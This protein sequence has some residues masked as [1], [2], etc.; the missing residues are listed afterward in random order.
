MTMS[1]ENI[2]THLREALAPTDN[3][4]PVERAFVYLADIGRQMISAMAAL[5]VNDPDLAVSDAESKL[6]A[7]V[8]PFTEAIAAID[9]DMSRAVMAVLTNPGPVPYDH[10]TPLFPQ[11]VVDKVTREIVQRDAAFDDLDK[12]A[13]ARSKA[14]QTGA[15]F[16]T[17]RDLRRSACLYAIAELAGK[18]WTEAEGHLSDLAHGYDP[19]T[20]RADRTLTGFV[21]ALPDHPARPHIVAGKF[22][23]DK[24][25]TCPPGKCPLNVED[26]TAQDLLWTY[27]QRRRELDAEFADDLEYALRNAGYTPGSPRPATSLAPG[28]VNEFTL[29]A[30]AVIHPNGF[31]MYVDG[32]LMI[33][34]T[35]TL[36][37]AEPRK[38]ACDTMGLEFAR[39]ELDEAADALA[40]AKRI[41][42]ERDD[43]DDDLRIA[44][45]IHEAAALEFARAELEVEYQFP[46]RG[47][48]QG[49]MIEHLRAKADPTTGIVKS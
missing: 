15:K 20:D 36:A 26:P 32:S 17:A 5:R 23:S 19:N 16:Y 12:T 3:R 7:A 24:Y 9:A 13:L 6:E 40:T 30:D 46:D 34:S 49:D 45:E 44:H 21:F 14:V 48:P 4:D 1:P 31:R 27:A 47:T 8:A 11:T 35:V 41:D 25:P 43:G 42:A 10:T 39:Q 2:A 38:R 37:S 28:G 18:G 33:T 29:N 22:Q